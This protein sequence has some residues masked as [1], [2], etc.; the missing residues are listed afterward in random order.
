MTRYTYSKWDGSQR[1]AQLDEET[2][3]DALAD[4]LMEHGNLR[5]ALRQLLRQGLQTP[6]GSMV[7]GFNDLMQ[8]LRETRQDILDREDMNSVMKGLQ[9]KLDEVVA[10]EREAIENRIDEARQTLQEGDDEKKIELQEFMDLLESRMENNRNKLES[11]PD[12]MAE[13]IKQLQ[14]YEFVSQDARSKFEELLAELRGHGQGTVFNQMKRQVSEFD[15]EQM[16]RMNDMLKELTQLLSDGL[17]GSAPDVSEFVEKYP[18]FF[19][20]NPPRNL[21]SLLDAL[22]R[23]SAA[24]Q[25]LMNSLSSEQ[26]SELQQAMDAVM[27][28]ELA[29]ILSELAD[30]MEA[31]FPPN[32]SSPG[33]N[34]RGNEDMNLSQALDT[35]QKL[36]RMDQLEQQL[37]R[38]LRE[39][40]MSKINR[41]ELVELLGDEA[42]QALET[43]ENIADSLRQAGYLQGDND[44]L[45]LT[46]KA[47]RRLGRKALEEVFG[48]LKN[49]R[50]HG[51]H[52][53]AKLGS[54][55]I[56]SGVTKRYEFGDELTH[57]DLRATVQNSVLRSGQGI[58]VK[59]SV[60][61]FEIEFTE[62][63]TQVS[64]VLLLDQSRSM[65]MWGTF[66][67]AKKVVM[68]LSALLQSQFPQDKLHVVGF[69]DFAKVVP[70][71]T[72]SKVTWNDYVSGTNMHHA[73]MLA[74]QL[75]AIDHTANKQIMMITDG[76]P[77]CYM[78]NGYSN[79]SYPPSQKTIA[80]TLKE[81][82]RCTQAGITINTFMLET[83]SYLLKFVE[84]MMKLN[85]GRAFYSSIDQLGRYVLVD[86]LRNKTQ[87]I[88]G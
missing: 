72:L 35:V 61:D 75:L 27:G 57:M 5:I 51:G 83:T 44:E 10:M 3:F 18:E 16:R 85:K 34:F 1:F 2:V 76:E 46:A 37:Y 50:I 42:N 77:T 62:V 39:A 86:Y 31:Y 24:G 71:E 64:T 43:M 80:E 45:T 47:T 38:A 63:Q 55:F 8:Q 30:L 88:V 20:E 23:S 9:D 4:D 58:P 48:S 21:D 6:D 11:L 49:S 17:R 74:R 67:G 26:R 56:K 12:G 33:Y 53:V 22:S 66:A 60:E 7:P 82:K 70:V 15:P 41:E 40:D 81:V 14:E 69:S 32:Q 84:E 54:G 29:N 79:F 78:E 28:N 68:A 52:Q 36:Q 87:R 73:L 65:G 13:N 59:L 25:A 19:G